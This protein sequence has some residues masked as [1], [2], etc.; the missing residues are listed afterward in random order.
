DAKGGRDRVTVLPAAI[1]VPLREHLAKPFDR[2]EHERKL[3]E[4]GV[5]LPCALVRKYPNAAMQW[6]WQWLFPSNSLCRDAYTGA[7]TRQ[8]QHESFSVRSKPLF[9]RRGSCSRR[10]AIPFDIA[11]PPTCWRPATTFALC[12]NCWGMP[13]C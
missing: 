5:S 8:H 9:E 4:P 1:I 10:A 13:M 11:L 12:R 6:G 2:F 7:F 3:R